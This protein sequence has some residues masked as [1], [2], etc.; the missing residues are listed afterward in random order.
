M[1]LFSLLVLTIS[2]HASVSMGKT[3]YQQQ[4][5]HCHNIEGKYFASHKKAKE[6]KI[7]LNTD[8]LKNIHIK[9]KLALPYFYSLKYE[10]HKKHLKALLQKYSKDRGSHNSCN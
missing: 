10:E 6:W 1:K 5:F 8:Y 2:L 4:C 3:I 7:L 9:N